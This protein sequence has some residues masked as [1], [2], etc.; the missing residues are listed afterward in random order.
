MSWGLRI[1]EGEGSCALLTRQKQADFLITDD[2]RALPELQKLT[3]VTVAIS[4]IVLKA[5][6]KLNLLKEKEAKQF[7]E[8]IAESRDWLGAPTYTEQRNSFSNGSGKD[9]YLPIV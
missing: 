1:D 4:P 3:D 6:V 5:M 8:E 9:P 2:I 7:V